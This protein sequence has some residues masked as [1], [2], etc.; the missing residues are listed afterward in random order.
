MAV[1]HHRRLILIL[2]PILFFIIFLNVLNF[3]KNMSRKDITT[4]ADQYVT[5][6][7]FNQNRLCKIDKYKLTFSDSNSAI[8]EVEGMEYKVPHKTTVLKLTMTKDKRGLWYV[9]KA[10]P[11]SDISSL[12]NSN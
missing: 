11:C 1:K 12:K 5:T 10:E 8:L 6:G 4:A 2:L 3:Y 9:K 7:F